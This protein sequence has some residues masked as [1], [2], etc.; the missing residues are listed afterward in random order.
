VTGL[1]L[2]KR[3]LFLESFAATA[4]APSGPKIAV[5][6]PTP[7]PAGPAD[8]ALRIE[9]LVPVAAFSRAG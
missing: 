4:R 9:T 8:S 5:R 1:S 7:E 3:R 2:A 6:T